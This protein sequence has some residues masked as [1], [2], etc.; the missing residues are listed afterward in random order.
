M[1][2]NTVIDDGGMI[3]H[4]RSQPI[5]GVMTAIAFQWRGH[6]GRRFAGCGDAIMATAATAIGFIMVHRRRRHI[7]P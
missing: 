5:G 2:A 4:R 3:R 6:M 1:T 7:G